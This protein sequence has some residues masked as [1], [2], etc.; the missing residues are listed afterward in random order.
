MGNGSF[1]VHHTRGLL[2]VGGIVVGESGLEVGEGAERFN[3]VEE[4]ITLG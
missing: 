4:N 3:G 2:G 1:E